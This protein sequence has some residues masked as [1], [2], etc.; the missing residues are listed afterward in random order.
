[1][2]HGA[3]DSQITSSFMGKPT[4][5]DVQNYSEIHGPPDVG[6]EAYTRSSIETVVYNKP[7]PGSELNHCMGTIYGGVSGMLLESM[8]NRGDMVR[9][10]SK[11]RDAPR[12]HVPGPDFM[13][14]AS[15]GTV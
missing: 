14:N 9:N 2:V 7:K 5:A 11:S 13:S 4:S 10:A 6:W 3:A 8:L 15:I 12:K 1:M